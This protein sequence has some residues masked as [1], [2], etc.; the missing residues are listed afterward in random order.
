MADEPPAYTASG[1]SLPR[2]NPPLNEKQPSSLRSPVA[3]SIS[4]HSRSTGLLRAQDDR[5][6]K[7]RTARHSLSMTGLFDVFRKSRLPPLAEAP[8]DMQ[9]LQAAIV[10]DVRLILQP[11]TGSVTERLALLECCTELSTRHSIDFSLLLQDRSSFHTHT[12]LYWAIVNNL[13]SPLAPFELV[14]AVLAKSQPL[15]PQT[16]KDVR[17]ACISHRSQDMF[18]FLRM[19]PEFGALPAEDR[20]ILGVIAPPEEITVETMDGPEQAFSV[21]FQI[22]MF[23]RRMTLSRV[24]PLEFIARDRLWRLSFYTAE[25]R[26]LKPKGNLEWFNKKQWG[27]HLK[28]CENSPPTHIEFGTVL[29]DTRNAAAKP[30]HD[31]HRWCPQLPLRNEDDTPNECTSRGWMWPM[32]GKYNGVQADHVCIAPDGSLTGILGVK[33]RKAKAEKLARWPPQTIPSKPEDDCVIC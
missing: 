9:T 29:L 26:S 18:Q 12:A 19:C 33:L 2:L 1:S 24:I 6:S 13:G 31:W 22:P 10:D 7:S 14:A 3:A 15:Q 17:R 32:F 16:I 11:N 30:A 23:Q 27:A 20:F 8:L 21:K 4:S 5:G 28:L 25:Q